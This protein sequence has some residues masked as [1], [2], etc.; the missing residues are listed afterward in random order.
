MVPDRYLVP[1][2]MDDPDLDRTSH[3]A[4]LRG[5]RRINRWTRSATHAWGPIAALARAHPARQIRVLDVA[6]GSADLP[7]AL[8][9]RARREGL[10]LAIDACDT[11]DV[12][13]EVAAEYCA[14]AGVSVSLRRVDALSDDLVHD[15]APRYDALTC[16][17]FLHHLDEADATTLLERMFAA[18]RGRLVVIDLERSTWNRRLVGCAARL[19]T[20]STVVHADAVQ[21]VRAAFTIDEVTRLAEDAGV[22]PFTV[23]RRR[24]CRFR[25][26]ADASGAHP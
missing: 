9:L 16:S 1:E 22:A 4:A 14:R 26:I 7:I 6:T 10:D 15:G 2:R 18:T 21:S 12:A 25:L 19:L 24:P 5:L 17:L 20:R 8:A 13:L 3:R 11:S 23:E